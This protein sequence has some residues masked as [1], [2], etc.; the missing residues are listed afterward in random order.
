LGKR[1]T[2]TGNLVPGKL[3]NL[4]Q[5]LRLQEAALSREAAKQLKRS[6]EMAQ[7]EGRIREA[8]VA[9]LRHSLRLG[10]RRLSLRRLELAVNCGAEL[11]QE[12]LHRCAEL[13]LG[14][15]DS[16]VHERLARLS[17]KLESADLAV[18]A[19]ASPSTKPERC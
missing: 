1:V 13:A 11:T 17:R 8:A 2:D 10:H 12:D 9:L 3:P 4:V 18:G 7:G 5:P 15:R 6:L 16:R 14:L 19:S